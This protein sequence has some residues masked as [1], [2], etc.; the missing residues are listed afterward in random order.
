MICIC[1]CVFNYYER[2]K[3]G[4]SIHNYKVSYR[5]KKSHCSLYLV[6]THLIRYFMHSKFMMTHSTSDESNLGLSRI[7][8]TAPIDFDTTRFDCIYI[9]VIYS[10]I[11]INNKQIYDHIL[12]VIEWYAVITVYFVKIATPYQSDC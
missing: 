11:Q 2:P 1:T 5:E 3:I 6:Y 8:W 10:Y 9:Y 4:D 7:L 12:S